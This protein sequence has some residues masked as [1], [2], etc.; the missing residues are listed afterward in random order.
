[1]LMVQ[2]TTDFP[3]AQQKFSSRNLAS[4]EAKSSEAKQPPTSSIGHLLPTENMGNVFQRISESEEDRM[5]SADNDSISCIVQYPPS[6]EY[7]R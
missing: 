2:L 4:A 6:N 1:M 5:P 3:T 7:Q